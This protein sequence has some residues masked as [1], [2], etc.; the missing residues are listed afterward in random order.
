MVM[1]PRATAKPK[2]WAFW[3]LQTNNGWRVGRTNWAGDQFEV[4][5]PDEFTCLVGVCNRF[6]IA[7]SEVRE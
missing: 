5:T 7:I 2:P 3:Y 4:L 1:S 6:A